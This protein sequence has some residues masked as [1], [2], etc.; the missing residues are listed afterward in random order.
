MKIKI[1][2]L[3]SGFYCVWVDGNWI[4]ASYRSLDDA[5]RFVDHIVQT[6]NKKQNAVNRFVNIGIEVCC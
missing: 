1:T 6:E 3:P 5:K 2:K 4:N